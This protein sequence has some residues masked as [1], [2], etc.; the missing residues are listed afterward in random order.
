MFAIYEGIDD[1][2]IISCDKNGKPNKKEFNEYIDAGINLNDEYDLEIVE[3][4]CHI[5]LRPHVEKYGSVRK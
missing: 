4:S 2:I 1:V 5:N 3:K